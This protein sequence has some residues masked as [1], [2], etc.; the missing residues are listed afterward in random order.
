MF[1]A[2]DLGISSMTLTGS[3]GGIITPA[4]VGFVAERAG[5][6]AGMGIVVLMTLLL[7]TTIMIHSISREES[8]Q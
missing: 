2:N 3:A 8:K 5:I 6:H 4:A 7:L 1:A